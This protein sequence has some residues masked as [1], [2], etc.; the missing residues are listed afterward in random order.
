[1]FRPSTADPSSDSSPERPSDP[2]DIYD[3]ED[4][5][6]EDIIEVGRVSVAP[7]YTGTGKTGPKSTPKKS[8]IIKP[9]DS[10]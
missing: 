7:A 10:D 6:D 5:T 8:R 4:V 2:I 1:L 9:T 3:F